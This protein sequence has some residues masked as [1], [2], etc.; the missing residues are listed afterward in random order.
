MAPL[1]LEGLEYRKESFRKHNEYYSQFIVPETLVIARSILGRY[2]DENRLDAYLNEISLHLWDRSIVN[3]RINA[4]M[5]R[6]MKGQDIESKTTIISKCD[7]ICILK[8]AARQILLGKG[9]VEVWEEPKEE[10]KKGWWECFLVLPENTL[11]GL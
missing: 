11:K 1:D 2:I 7:N 6:E 4:R 5:Y 9:F 8:C 3:S 10:Y